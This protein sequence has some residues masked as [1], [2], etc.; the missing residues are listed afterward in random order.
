[1]LCDSALRDDCYSLEDTQA[2]LKG[3]FIILLYHQI[4]LDPKSFFEEVKIK[5]SRIQ[6]IP[7]S[8]Q[9]RLM[10][11]LQVQLTHLNTQDMELFNLNMWTLTSRKDL[12]TLNELKNKPYEQPDNAWM[13]VSVE[14]DLNRLEVS[15]S[16]Y[17]VLDLL[18]QFGGFIGIFGRIFGFFMAAW[19]INAME[20]YMVSRL[21]KTLSRQGQG[22]L[23]QEF[24]RSKLP[25]CGDYLMT[26]VPSCFVCCQ[27]RGRE[28]A[29]ALARKD[30]S[31]EFDMI[32]VI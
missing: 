2:W 30:L 24:K 18:A 26:W 19:N 28:K 17:T 3:K 8:S 15:R 1:M 23:K 29:K 7:I 22:E 11:P 14:M 27:K 16:R 6:Y 12:F 13:S 9:S 32:K 20:N 4:R 31:A 10:V 5:E 21:Y 25:H